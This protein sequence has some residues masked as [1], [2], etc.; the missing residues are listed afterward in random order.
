M[1]YFSSNRTGRFEIW[2]MP[3]D[4]GGAVPIT[5]GGGIA[6]IEGRDGFLYYAK[7]P[8]LPTSIWRV[9]VAGGKETLVLDGLS[10]VSNFAVGE[11]G[12]YFTSQGAS[13][14]DT[15][16]EY[17]D[18]FAGRRTRLSA[19]GKQWWYGGALSPD[20]KWLVYSVVDRIDNRLMVVD[21]PW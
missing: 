12:L 7:A 18:V 20:E 4:G 8:Q 15:N 17:F 14:S 1:T 3:A 21:K 11:R 6:G 2:K 19:I 10:Y 16:I 5:T 13:V 9:P